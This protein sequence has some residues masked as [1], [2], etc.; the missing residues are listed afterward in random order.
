MSIRENILSPFLGTK[1]IQTT[2]IP[3]HG[4]TITDIFTDITTEI[5]T[6]LPATIDSI[7]GFL[8]LQYPTKTLPTPW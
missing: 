7:T 6:T 1:V 5:T 2:S 8:S 3:T 4:Q